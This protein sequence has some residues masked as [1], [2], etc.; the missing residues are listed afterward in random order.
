MRTY[1]SISQSSCTVLYSHQQC[2]GFQFLHIFPNTCN[3][4][5]LLLPPSFSSFSFPF[6][7]DNSHPSICKLASQ[8]VLICIFLMTSEVEHL[9]IVSL[10][11]I[12]FVDMSSPLSA[13]L[14]GLLLFVFMSCWSFFYI[15]DI[16][17]L[18]DIWFSNIFSHLE[19]VFSLPWECPL[20]TTVF[21]VTF[22]LFLLTVCWC[23]T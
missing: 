17:C 11:Y 15:V 16:N 23:R 7:F 10:L 4:F 2:T 13:F 9:F 18:P 19:A 8:L 6:F 1:Q 20:V 5:F 12:F 14:V 21:N 3:F 22:Y